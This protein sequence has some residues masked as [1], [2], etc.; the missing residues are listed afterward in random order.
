[1]E[2]EKGKFLKTRFLN[3]FKIIKEKIISFNLLAIKP[4]L[5]IADYSSKPFNRT[6]LERLKVFQKR[7]LY[8]SIS[9]LILFLLIYGMLF[10]CF[11]PHL[12]FKNTTTNGGDMGAH[13]Y[14][15]K[16]FIDELFPDLRMTGWDTGWFAGMPML[17]FY[18]PLP[19]LLIAILSKVFTYNIAFKLITVLGSLMLPVSLYLFAKLFRFKYPFPEFAAIGAMA[20]LYMKSFKIYGGNFLG[21]FAGEFSYSI[22]FALVF[23]FIATLYRGIESGRFDWLFALNSFILSCVVLT[24]LIT[25]IA[26]LVIAPCFFV[27]NRKW[28][29]ARY[30]IAVFATGFFLSAFWSVPFVL[31]ISYTPE[32]V[33][34]NIKDLKEMFPLELVPALVLAV[35]GLF[36]STL[37]RDKKTTVIIWT[38]ILFMSLFF[39]WNGGRLYNARFLPFIFTF[40]YLIAAYGLSSLYWIFISKYPASG[41]NNY[42]HYSS[43]SAPALSTEVNADNVLLKEPVVK[44]KSF[45]PKS[46]KNFFNSL[47]KW[48]GSR[49]RIK[50]YRFMVFAFVPIIAFLAGAAILAGNP[51]GPAWARHNFTGFEDKEEWQTYNSLMTYLDS[52]PYGR[53]MFEFNKEIIQKYGTPRSFE[54]I[55]F[56]TDQ[57]GMEGL[58]VESSL[59]SPFHYINQAELSVKPRGTVA[60]W[61]VPSRN[62]YAAMRHLKLMNITYIMASSPEVVEDL[63]NDSSVVF[64]N[65]IDPY[66]FYE[67][68][69]EHNYVEIMTN[70]PYRYSPE[71]N[72]ILEMRDWYLNPENTDNPVIMD[73]GS[74][75]LS[76]LKVIDK[77]SLNSVPDN[78]VNSS[79]SENEMVLYEHVERE[80]ITFN[81]TAVGVPHLVKMSYFPNWQA[82]GADG[83]YL[84]SPSFMMVIPTGNEVTLF[85]GM[86]F[87]NKLGASLTALGWAIIA[88]V[89]VIN[90]L[91][92][93]KNKKR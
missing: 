79:N 74:D 34:T 80:K 91:K 40:I 47:K 76:I 42:R 24:H 1:M 8:F 87:A 49:L 5:E 35:F 90:I 6:S 73:D 65:K 51:L 56:W 77:D 60:G 50:F 52:L 78:P 21:T 88:A 39:T 81:T 57:A 86:A 3:T 83:P 58:L 85:Y 41:L 27:F 14:I 15:A 92:S 32:M 89:L 84:V 63:D 38:I 22:S 31:H 2:Q 75:E 36:F 30:I 11:P 26:L 17:T 72:W 55:P 64:L 44:N 46:I 43:R 10:F 23:I 66:Y 9:L 70:M 59:T 45:W 68:R 33:W 69:G 4:F 7:K 53:V 18:F 48:A 67:I 29:C 25:V 82:V 62:Y 16:Y 93:F 37:K 19:Y 13:N 71:E 54:L 12:L 20:F 61:K 28:K